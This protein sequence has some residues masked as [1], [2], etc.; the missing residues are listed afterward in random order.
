MHKDAEVDV[1]HFCVGEKCEYL[2]NFRYVHCLAL[3]D[4]IIFISIIG[5]ASQVVGRC[6]T[7]PN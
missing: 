4:L 6:I 5:R 1:G 2:Q 3:A 7:Y